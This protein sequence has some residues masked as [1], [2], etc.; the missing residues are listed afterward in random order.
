M[1]KAQIRA[2][3]SD[4]LANLKIDEVSKKDNI[5]NKIGSGKDNKCSAASE[6]SSISFSFP[7]SFQTKQIV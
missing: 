2:A 4:V 1:G 5:C 7:P 6:S 3:A